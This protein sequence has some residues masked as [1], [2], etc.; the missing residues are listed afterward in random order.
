MVFIRS[1]CHLKCHLSIQPRKR[2]AQ[3][4]SARPLELQRAS[5]S[6]TSNPPAV[7]SRRMCSS[8]HPLAWIAGSINLA[9]CPLSA[10]QARGVGEAAFAE[11][12]A[13]GGEEAEFA[14]QSRAAAPA[15]ESTGSE[16][17]GYDAVAGDAGGEGVGAKGLTD[18][19]RGFAPDETPE[20]GV[21]DDAACGDFCQGVIDAAS[22]GGDGV[23]S[24]Q[25]WGRGVG[26]GLSL[27]DEEKGARA[28]CPQL[29]TNAGKMPALLFGK[30]AE[31]V[32]GVW[33]GKIGA[34]ACARGV[35]IGTAVPPWGM[36]S[37]EG[38]VAGS[39]MDLL[40]TEIFKLKTPGCARANFARN[41]SGRRPGCDTWGRGCA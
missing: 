10:Q 23:C 24:F 17:R 7:S 40:K 3:V 11:G 15:L 16:V 4:W 31:G 35:I 5:P 32:G 38:E 34:R 36:S 12:D 6:T 41:R 27:L 33:V 8:A 39:G 2:L 1:K 22:E 28:S 21:G 37:C 26:N 13:F 30:W 19:A 9:A 25:C 29:G 18:G 14:R 20:G